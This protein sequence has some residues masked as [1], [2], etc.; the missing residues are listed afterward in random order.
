MVPPGGEEVVG[1][2]DVGAELGGGTELLDL[3]ALVVD[4]EVL[5]VDVEVVL[6]AE[7]EAPEAAPGRH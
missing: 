5:V 1:V 2:P 3:E 7:L 6:T 4:L